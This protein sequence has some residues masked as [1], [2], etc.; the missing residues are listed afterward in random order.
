MWKRSTT[1]AVAVALTSL[2]V[3]APG[4]HAAAPLSSDNVNNNLRGRPV[5]EALIDHEESTHDDNSVPSNT[6]DRILESTLSTSSED[7]DGHYPAKAKDDYHSNDVLFSFSSTLTA[8]NSN[9]MRQPPPRNLAEAAHAEDASHG[10]GEGGHGGEDSMVVHVTYEQIYAILVFLMTATALGIVTSKLGMP[11]LVGEIITGF[12]LGPPLADF[13]PY[14]EAFVLV[15]EIGLIMLLLEAGVE[16]DVAQL[17]ETGARALG[18]GVTGT[19]LPLVVG[20]GLAMASDTN[21]GIKSALAVGASFSP[22]SLGVAASALKQGKMLD[23]PVGQ[24]IVSSCVVDDILALILLSMFQ[25]LVED[26]PPIV[27]YFIPFISSIGFLIVLGGSAV[28]WL[29]TFIQD[30]IL[31]KLPEPYRD[32]TMFSIMTAML[33]AYLPLLNYTKSSYL[34]G[35]F[36]AGAT[37]SQIESAHHAF[38]E[39]THQLMTWLLRV[40]FAASIGFQVPVKLFSDPY[41][42]GWGF[43]LYCCVLAKNPLMLYVPQFEDVKEGASYN[44]FLRDRLITGLAMTCR[45]EFSFIIAAFALGKNLIS[46]Q[47]Y[48]AIVWA[49]LLSCITSPFILLSLIKYFNKQ[50]LEY[51]KATNPTKQ[52]TGS[53]GMTPLYLHIKST[54]PASWGQQ[55]IFRQ[56]LN[57]MNLE[58]M[59]RRTNRNGRT[60]SA[61][62]QTDL[63]VK[64]KSMNVKFQKIAGQKRI[65]NALK[66]AMEFTRDELDLLS[67]AIQ[68]LQKLVDVDCASFFM[69]FDTN[70]DGVVSLKELKNGLEK[71][72]RLNLSKRQARK[73]MDLFDGSK[74][75]SLQEDEMV[76]LNEFKQRLQT[77]MDGNKKKTIG[78]MS[79]RLSSKSLSQM[80]LV[81]LEKEAQTALEE[82]AK[83]QDQI[84]ARGTEIEDS[85][86]RALG[87][88]STVVVDVWN[89]W[90][91][92]E[93][94]DKI[95]SHY[96][97][98]TVDHFEAVFAS[99]DI[100]GGGTVDQEEI[101][102]ALLQAGVD[103][104]EEGVAT[105]FNMIDEDGSGEID[106]EEWKE[107]ADFY[108]ELKEEENEKAR[109]ENDKSKAQERLRK[110][111]LAKLGA[112]AKSLQQKK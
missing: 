88:E 93:L 42:I 77:T 74:D 99:I 92:T 32:L 19:I 83:E 6:V 58:V 62:V 79:S 55:E 30:K 60:L 36:L 26:D 76:S 61:E 95:A 100:D 66:V 4:S 70:N 18:I 9:V 16:L 44:P 22:T 73:V 37:F 23:T 8:P 71:E 78:P 97:L 29:P 98:E 91:W 49:V 59:D 84:I 63:F 87:E 33:L 7:I 108:L 46:E 80:S 40:F 109:M 75:G 81:S 94:F 56:I 86:E 10:E 43:I 14:E 54:A 24:L 102:E 45:G 53:D 105:L 64:D 20:M 48:A 28:T 1:L 11:A 57:D 13:V 35:A 85:L 65:K 2:L 89:P 25:V 104:S 96:E 106:E 101:Y 67:D 72:L 17:R 21:I 69:Q 103:I 52:Y 34:T 90:P 50:Q 31:K 110:Q 41:V 112:Q 51:L 111:K 39:K 5:G 3:L 38:I 47:I 27:S 107:A 82:V 15:G 68:E 12:L